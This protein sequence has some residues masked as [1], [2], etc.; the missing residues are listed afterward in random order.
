MSETAVQVQF[1]PRMETVSVIRAFFAGLVQSVV[2]PDAASRMEIAAQELLEN[3]VK[4]SATGK[5]DARLHLSPGQQGFDAL[6][7]TANESSPWDRK[8]VQ[9]AVDAATG[10]AAARD[11]YL[12]LMRRAATRSHGSGLGIGRVVAEAEMRVECSL[13]GER[14]RV[15]ATAV[16]GKEHT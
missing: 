8:C 12:S 11:H 7:E 15:K 1:E 16:F 14:V 9:R 3:A 4:G 5:V 6:L 2:G 10:A 13:E